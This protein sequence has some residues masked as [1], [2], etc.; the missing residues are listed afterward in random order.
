MLETIRQYAA[1][2]LGSDPEAATTRRYHAEYFL[3]LAEA[4]NPQ[5]SGSEQGSWLARLESE[6]DNLRA[7]LDWTLDNREIDLAARLA[8]SLAFF[9]DF[10]G[11]L[12]EG[13]KWLGRVLEQ[14]AALPPALKARVLLSAGS[15]AH[16]QADL[17][18]AETLVTASWR[19]QEHLGEKHDGAR[20][21]SILG[22]VAMDR[23]DFDSA[24]SYFEQGAQLERELN[25]AHGVANVLSNMALAELYRENFQKA[26]E[27][28]G[29]CL[30]I[31]RQLGDQ[32]GIATT[33]ANFGEAARM[34]GNSE[35]ARAL[36]VEALG[37]AWRLDAKHILLACLGGLATLE[38]AQ[39]NSRYAAWLYGVE[40]A[41]R[42][43][44]GAPLA[45]V[46]QVEYERCVAQTRSQMDEQLFAQ[47]WQEGRSVTLEQA[48]HEITL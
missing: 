44:I 12:T 25:D 15:L 30:A 16:A 32:R 20:S 14:A 3:A 18:S 39:G 9:W 34:Q 4:A 37:L 13:S 35:Q 27:A 40:E 43:A 6:H 10:R 36:F 19:V 24:V 26:Q 22:L 41:L 21:L 31:Y 42:D 7:A 46:D 28:F 1:Q 47:V 38:T 17:E 2:L 11:Y 8:T 23:G 29:E 48:I 45:P 5:L 33:L